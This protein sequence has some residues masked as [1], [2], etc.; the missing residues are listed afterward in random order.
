MG[1]RPDGSTNLAC[2][3]TPTPRTANPLPPPSPVVALAVSDN[4]VTLTFGATPGANYR[5]DYKDTLS[6]PHWQPL[7]TAQQAAGA[8]VSVT[9]PIGGRSQRFYR[10]VVP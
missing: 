5:V 7:A 9:D 1:R 8:T 2:F 3:L 4:V 6:A 10:V